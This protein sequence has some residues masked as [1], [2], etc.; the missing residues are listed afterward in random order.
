[1]F[2]D[3][4]QLYGM[5][6]FQS[7]ASIS[8][9]LYAVQDTPF[10][11]AG[12]P[13]L[14]NSVYIRSDLAA[15][16]MKN[17]AVPDGANAFL[18]FLFSDDVQTGRAMAALG[19]PVTEQALTAAFPV[20]YNYYSEVFTGQRPQY[21]K[22][23]NVRLSEEDRAGMTEALITTEQRDDFLD[24]LRTARLHRAG[25]DKTILSIIEEELSAA[26]AG[27]RSRAEAAKI[28]QNRVLL[29]LNE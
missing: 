9:T 17:T 25:G 11:Y 14:G 4:S 20:G 5:A 28:I 8:E 23:S 18:A 29:Y 13:L 22:H 7:T 27:V 26:D 15:A 3:G 1:M 21:Q 19:L 24:Y 2:A 6:E 10:A 16:V 12:F